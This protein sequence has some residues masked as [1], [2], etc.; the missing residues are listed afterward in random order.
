MTYRQQKFV[1]SQREYDF[2]KVLPLPHWAKEK[3]DGVRPP[4][5]VTMMCKRSLRCIIDLLEL[6]PNPLDNLVHLCGGREV[7]AE[8]TGR[9]FMMEVQPDGA[10]KKVRRTGGACTC[11]RA[12]HAT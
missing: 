1:V 5:P 2:E 6:P 10:F 9:K 7:V 11:T 12:R 8:L 4:H 3:A